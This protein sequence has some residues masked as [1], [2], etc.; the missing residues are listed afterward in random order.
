MSYKIHRQVLTSFDRPIVNGNNDMAMTLDD[1]RDSGHYVFDI[2]RNCDNSCI[3]ASLSDQS[4]L[5]YDSSLLTA[6]GKINAHKDKINSI[7]ASVNS[8]FVF[9][10]ASSDKSVSVWDIR[11]SCEKSI[12]V[13][14]IKHPGEVTGLSVTMNDTLLA[15]AC[16]T[17][18]SFFDIRYTG[19]G[20]KP[21]KLGEYSDVHTDEI[22]QLKFNR[23]YPSNLVSAAEDGLI[24]LYDTSKQEE[25]E[26]VI[27][28]LNTECPI[29]RFGFFGKENEGIYCLSTTETA[30][31]WHHPSAIRVGNFMNIRQ[32]SC[33]DYLVDCIYNN[34]DESLSLIAGTYEGK[35]KV[36]NLEPTCSQ[37]TGE[38][39]SG[40]N[41]S[42]RCA[43]AGQTVDNMRGC[44][45]N[46]LITGGE[47]SQ[48]CVWEKVNNNLIINNN[49]LISSNN[50]NRNNNRNNN[51]SNNRSKLNSSRVNE[52]KNRRQQPYL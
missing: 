21:S 44:V 23:L 31:V 29:R 52:A 33:V 39:D 20:S 45:F 30:S 32:E 13:A 5:L 6:K 24:C 14:N 11:I 27:S 9:Y 51:S 16:G 22:T 18:I 43:I 41:A 28:I 42:I 15:S 2:D 40:H 48:I 12:S 1:Q 26:A 50:S 38:C 4:V 10:S 17:T 25:E 37:V 47:D 35:G 7:E 8:P 36:I 46:Q 34:E 19:N 49:S 3:L